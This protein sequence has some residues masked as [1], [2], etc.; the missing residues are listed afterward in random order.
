MA[1]A[2][3]K[4]TTYNHDVAGMCTRMHRFIVEAKKSV[5]SGMAQVNEFDQQ[6]LASYL[7]AM[8]GY[9]DWVVSQPQLDLPETHPRLLEVTLMPDDDVENIENESLRDVCRLWKLAILELASS[10]SSRSSSGLVKFDEARLRAII[11][12]TQALLDNYIKAID[13]LDLPE[14]SPA[15]PMSGAGKT[16]V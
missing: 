9:A 12:K 8:T 2:K 15:Y 6:R 7:T 1:D 14:S 10:Q 3:E 5:S 11:A 16:G 13:P 4:V